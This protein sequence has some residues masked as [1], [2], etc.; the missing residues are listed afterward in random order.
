MGV[1]LKDKWAG[2]LATVDHA[3]QP[4]VNAHSALVY[5]FEALLRN[6]GA[7]GFDSIAALFDSAHADGVLPS[8]E[9]ALRR[10]ALEKFA[11]LPFAGRVK[12][13]CNVDNRAFESGDDRIDQTMEALTALNLPPSALCIEISERHGAANP[14]AF[15]EIL[16]SHR[17][18]RFKIAVDDFGQG[19]SGLRMLYDSEP[20]IIKIDRFFVHGIA[21]DQRR[22]LFVSKI[23]ALAKSLGI[24]VVAEGVEEA[25]DLYACREIGCDLVQGYLIA[26]PTIELT[27]LQLSYEDRIRTEKRQ[28]HHGSLVTR[29][30]E[31]L[32]ELAPVRDTATIP[33]VIALFAETGVD[34]VVPVVDAAGEP[35]GLI[36]EQ[37]IKPFI[38]NPYGRDLLANK[39]VDR[40]VLRITSRCP[41]V[42]IT[43]P[44]EQLV[45]NYVTDEGKE[46]LLIVRDR[47]YAGFLSSRALIGMIAERNVAQAR[48]QNPLTGLPG[49][50]AILDFLRQALADH[51]R[52]YVMAYFDFDNFK[53][54]NDAYG[55]RQGD[56]VI[57]LFA[58]LLKLH[59]RR[60]DV[61]VAHLG[62]DDYVAGFVDMEL[63]EVRPRVQQLAQ[64]FRSD[65]ESFY[66]VADRQ[67]GGILGQDRDGS[68]RVFP[69]TR[70]STV[71]LD[72]PPNRAWLTEDE[73]VQTIALGKKRAKRNPEGLAEISPAN[74]DVVQLQQ[75]LRALL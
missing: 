41:V 75:R 39:G 29:I 55:F 47:Q 48:D 38:Y 74:T 65:V 30:A 60:D 63:D 2:V 35:V 23:V 33:E 50:G 20:D 54:F 12:L 19:Y 73:V 9:T 52:H 40:S 32:V 61:L 43:A 14:E 15:N 24:L 5:G 34:A 57:L 22:R 53:P 42:E 16:R 28:G 26:R 25:R 69:L 64:Q 7:A 71:L 49:N 62:G 56:R 45:N 31:E 10:K 46:G 18:E 17:H 70:V 59:L 4:I 36:R 11:R 66:D 8:L 44:V 13:F 6:T 68:E 27:E 58:N 67:R 72:L 37:D 51:G 21:D 1:L 3:F